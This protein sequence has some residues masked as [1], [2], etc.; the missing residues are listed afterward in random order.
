MSARV[1]YSHIV[2]RPIDAVFRFMMIDHIQNHPRWDEDIELEAT[3]DEPMGLGTIIRRRNRRSGTVV[4]GTIEV[5]EYKENESVTMVIREGGME[6]V[7]RADFEAVGDNSTRITQT[8]DLPGADE[9]MDTSMI[10]R[11]LNEV[12]DIRKVL[13][14]S[15]L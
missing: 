1:Q 9:S 4:E 14:E 12:G 10:V 13:M 6:I 7:G 2:E 11:R 15:E 5:T 3:S 8:I